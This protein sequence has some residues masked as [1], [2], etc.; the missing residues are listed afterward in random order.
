MRKTSKTHETALGREWREQLE[1]G[2]SHRRRT[3]LGVPG[4]GAASL[5]ALIRHM[6]LYYSDWHIANDLD[7]VLGACDNVRDQE[8]MREY[9]RLRREAPG[10]NPKSLTANSHAKI[11]TRSPDVK[12]YGYARKGQV[13]DLGKPALCPRCELWFAKKPR[14]RICA[15]CRRPDERAKM[16]GTRRPAQPVNWEKSLVT[17]GSKPTG[18]A[19]CFACGLAPAGNDYAGTFS[20]YCS[21]CQPRTNALE[22]A[23]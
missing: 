17:M 23:A 7:C 4:Q 5:Q 10:F 11:G 12:T 13:P 14:E 18:G 6:E 22:A 1:R 21:D 8:R 9:A 20:A 3:G 19:P 16:A 15:G 2:R